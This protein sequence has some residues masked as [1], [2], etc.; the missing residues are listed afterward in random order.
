MNHAADN[1]DWLGEHPECGY[2]L[3][4]TPWLNCAYALDKVYTEFSDKFCECKSQFKFQPY[5]KN[6]DELNQIMN[7]LRNLVY[8]QNLY[9]YFMIN[10]G[11]NRKLMEEFYDDFSKDRGKYQDQLNRV[12]IHNDGMAF[13][14]LYN[15]CLDKLG[16]ERNGVVVLKE[17][18]GCAFFSKIIS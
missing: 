10:I 18:F 8:K 2:N 12:N 13:D 15:Q 9:E 17:K 7:E 6:E 14:Y 16:E 5:V 4:N 1:S 11:Q 3:V